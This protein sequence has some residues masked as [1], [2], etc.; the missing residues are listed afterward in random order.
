MI[1]N[2]FYYVSIKEEV[3]NTTVP[4]YTGWNFLSLYLTGND[5]ATSV[6]NIAQLM[7]FYDKLRSVSPRLIF[8]SKFHGSKDHFTIFGAR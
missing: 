5:A 8:T 7:N 3:I 4:V 2:G 6:V 1:H